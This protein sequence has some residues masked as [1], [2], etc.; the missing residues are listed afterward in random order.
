[1][2]AFVRGDK[3]AFERLFEQHKGGIYRYFLRLTSSPEDAEDLTQEIWINVF[4]NRASYQ[5]KSKFTTW[6]Y[7][8]AHNR[9]IDYYRKNSRGVPISYA[10]AQ[11]EAFLLR[12]EGDL[13]LDEI[14]DA[15]QV[16]RET[17]KSRLR[18][19]VAKLRKSVTVS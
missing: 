14:A 5:P 15:T 19:A 6:I 9:L 1:M 11:R 16:T 7:A 10:E 3:G 4:R 13:S 8:I 12:E 17:A 18:Y 2:Q